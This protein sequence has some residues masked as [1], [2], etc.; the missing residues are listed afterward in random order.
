MLIFRTFSSPAQKHP[1]EGA[2]FIEVWPDASGV[3]RTQPNSR[4]YS[5][6]RSAEPRTANCGWRYS[7]SRTPPAGNTGDAGKQRQPPVAVSKRRPL[8]SAPQQNGHK[9]GSTKPYERFAKGGRQIDRLRRENRRARRSGS[10]G[11]MAGLA[12]V[13]TLAVCVVGAVSLVF[14]AF[15]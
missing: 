4:P 11:K 13:A 9:T 15:G 12:F 7:R 3:C 1:A 2:K 6:S 8:N 14:L 5:D 10:F